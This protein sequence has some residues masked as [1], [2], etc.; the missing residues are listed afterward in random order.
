MAGV[1][2][3][4][5]GLP[6]HIVLSALSGILFSTLLAA[7][8]RLLVLLSWLLLAAALLPLAGLLVLLSGLLLA[9][10]LI[11]LI[12]IHFISPVIP[13]QDLNVLKTLIVPTPRSIAP[14]C[15]EVDLVKGGEAETGEAKSVPLRGQLCVTIGTA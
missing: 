10:T 13:R 12:L 1:Q 4:S 8:A 11:L 14:R 15:V 7:L 2:C 5:M 3:R 9:A 6:L